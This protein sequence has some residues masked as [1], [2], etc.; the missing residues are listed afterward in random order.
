MSQ[1]ETA[2]FRIGW[3]AFWAQ[4][5][6]F[7]I[8]LLILFASWV[9]LEVCV[10]GL[11]GLGVVLNVLLHLAFLFAFCGLAAGLVVVAVEVLE[12]KEG[13]LES[14][15]GSLTRGP[16]VL[17]ASILYLLAVVAGFC[18]LVEPG[19]D[20]AVRWALFGMVLATDGVSAT[21]SLRASAELVEG[22]W[23]EACGFF[24]KVLLL[25]LAGAALL[26]VGLLVTVPV[27]L[28][29]TGSYYRGLTGDGG[30]PGG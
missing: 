12:G 5:R 19:V 17:L 14:L 7:V 13:R 10:I 4:P 9:A 21:E 24:T 20:L 2:H 23:G 27:T 6:V 30:P 8:S 22:R 29:A 25:N 26:G 15:L 16:Q 28:L 18:L 1:S 3:R 11:H